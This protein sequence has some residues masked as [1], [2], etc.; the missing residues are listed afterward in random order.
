MVTLEK[1]LLTHKSWKFYSIFPYFQYFY[2]YI[3][4]LF[5]IDLGTDLYIGIM[6]YF[7]SWSF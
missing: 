3:Y 7:L 4:Y 6:I 1:Y 5:K 2:T